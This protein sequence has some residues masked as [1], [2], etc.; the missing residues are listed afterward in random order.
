MNNVKLT[1]DYS[2][3]KECGICVIECPHHKNKSGHSHV[4]H[5]YEFCDLCMHCYAICP[6]HAVSTEG[7]GNLPMQINIM[8]DSLLAHFMYRRSYRRFTKKP[9]SKEI[10]SQ[11]LNAARFIPS[12][13]NDH[14]FQI[15]VLNSG[16]KRRELLSAIKKY[17]NKILRLMKNPILHFLAK[18]IGNEKVKAT[19][20]R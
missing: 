9:I 16:E 19:L 10:L 17:Y 4:D 1:I 8:P 14:R 6:E 12:G 11:L 18:W 5:G 13:G 15:T 2:L 3:C 20:F 7:D